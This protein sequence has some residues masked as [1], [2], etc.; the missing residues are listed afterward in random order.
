MYGKYFVLVS[1]EYFG[2]FAMDASSYPVEFEENFDCVSIVEY[3]KLYEFLLEK[4]GRNI[5]I[6]K[7]IDMSCVGRVYSRRVG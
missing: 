5:L 7:K 3:N 4:L 1:E 6:S 2:F